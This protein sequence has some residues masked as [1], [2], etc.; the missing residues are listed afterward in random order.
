MSPESR[1]EIVQTL[2]SGREEFLKTVQGLTE[3]DALAHPQ[4]GR[5]SVLECVEH[6]TMVEERF[7]GRIEKAP[8]EGAPEINPQ[9]EADL[10]ARVKDRTNRAEAPEFVRPTGR[11]QSLADALDSF[12]AVR[13]RTIRFA[14]DNA[15]DLYL[16]A[17]SH[18]RF[19]PL[20]G[21]EFLVMMNSHVLRHAAQLRELRSALGK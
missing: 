21:I 5:W 19:G 3:A 11:F 16:L 8:R 13:A 20:N 12:H 1:T 7:V 14:G 10:A 17:E 15:A 18:P 9:H 4:A 2:E 6:V